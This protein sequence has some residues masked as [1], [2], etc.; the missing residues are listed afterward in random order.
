MSEVINRV[1]HLIN[2]F[3]KRVQAAPGGSW[4]NQS[5]CSEWK[6]RDVVEHVANNLF[7]LAAGGAENHRKVTIADNITT[8]W[9]D[10]RV[11]F[12]RAIP[13]AD[14]AATVP[15]PM[16][17]MPLEDVLGRLV[18]ND[19]LVHTWDLARSVGGDERLDQDAV[20]GAY[21][22]LKPLD[23]MI[24]RPG[25]FGDKAEAPAGADLQTEFL[26]FLGRQV[27]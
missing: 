17:P 10:A 2:E 1:N 20:A 5:P 16:G 8:A 11:A 19:V 4:A 24:R 27:N 14:L 6:A 12:Q 13:H 18:A 23:A 26:S 25:I 15:G 22:G 7:R 21:S 3:D 9:T